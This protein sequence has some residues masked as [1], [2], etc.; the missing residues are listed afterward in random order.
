M[1]NAQLNNNTSKE[2]KHMNKTLTITCE[3]NATVRDSWHIRR[4]NEAHTLDYLGFDLELIANSNC[5]VIELPYDRKEQLLRGSFNI[6]DT[7]HLQLIMRYTSS[8][9]SCLT[10]E[11]TAEADVRYVE[12]KHLKDVDADLDIYRLA[13]Y[14][15]DKTDDKQEVTEDDN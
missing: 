13:F 14:L 11:D 1:N 15:K 9:I 3:G 5:I 8:L 2:D 4:G 6:T 10:Q 7:T 12:E